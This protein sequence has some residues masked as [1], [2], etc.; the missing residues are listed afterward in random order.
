[1]RGI[2]YTRIELHIWCTTT[3][4]NNIKGSQRWPPTGNRLTILVGEGI[5]IGNCL[6]C[7]SSPDEFE[8]RGDR[9]VAGRIQRTGSL[10][11]VVEWESRVQ[12]TRWEH[13]R[14]CSAWTRALCPQSSPTSFCSDG[15]RK[16]SCKIWGV[17]ATGWQVQMFSNH[18]FSPVSVTELN[19]SM[20][21]ATTTAKTNWELEGTRL[22][23]TN[24]KRSIWS[25]V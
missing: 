16:L 22:R 6:P 17:L 19:S 18:P 15:Q 10:A 11:G 1:M 5:R 12:L 13:N 4:I 3:Q 9:D 24:Q 25:T 2:E 23:V 21:S 7:A 8:W 14:G 20:K